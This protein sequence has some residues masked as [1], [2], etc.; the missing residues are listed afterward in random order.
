MAD[1]PT[2]TDTPPPPPPKPPESLKPS[3][4]MQQRLDTFRAQKEARQDAGQAVDHRAAKAENSAAREASRNAPKP[5]GPQQTPAQRAENGAPARR[6]DNVAPAQRAENGAPPRRADNVA[7]AQRAE[8]GAP[9]RRADNVASAQRAENGVPARR[10]ENAGPA[11]RSEHVAPGHRPENGAALHRVEGNRPPQQRVGEGDGGARHSEKAGRNGTSEAPGLRPSPEFQQ[12]LDDFRAQK[13]ARQDAGQAVDH[14][15]AKAENQA[16]RE[17][18]QQSRTEAVAVRQPRAEGAAQRPRAEE[19]AVRQPRAEE[20]AVR[21]P[22]AED[23]A[24]RQPRAE[25]AA[26][27]QPLAEAAGR[28]PQRVDVG[29]RQQVESQPQQRVA[30]GTRPQE[31]ARSKSGEPAG[32]RPSPEFQQKL[33]DLRAQKEA[34]QPEVGNNIDHQRPGETDTNR[35]SDVPATRDFFSRGQTRSNQEVLDNGSGT[36]MTLDNVHNV[37]GRMDV[38][39][40][41]VDVVIVND[42]EEIRYLDHMDAVAYTPS[43]KNGSEIRLGPASFADEETLAA[44]IAHEHTHVQQQRAGDHLHMSMED[45]EA[46]AYDSEIPALERLRNSES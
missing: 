34:R 12:K 11:Q 32:L 19:A 33:D 20:A 6:A 41:N 35:K 28:Q 45:L 39:L 22:R 5:E 36:P 23:A 25:D 13:E 14:R 42:P 40:R 31:A 30:E 43:E 15:A 10:A 3:P 7:S 38:D 9:P 29:G 2:R 37:A 21:Q 26:V 44:T 1:T 16:A 8:N 24:V 46:Q 27:R 17:A 18:A 4:E